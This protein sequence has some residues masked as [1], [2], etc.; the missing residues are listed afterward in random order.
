MNQLGVHALVWVPQWSEAECECALMGAKEAGYD[1]IEIPLLD[2]QQVDAG[3]TR[4]LLAQYGLSAT[5]SLGL[6]FDT[7]V[8]S[9]DPETSRRGEELL[10]R[11]VRV[12]SDLGAHYLGGV[13]YSAMGKYSAPAAPTARAQTAK[14][15]RRVAER[16]RELGVTVGLEPVNRYESNLINTARQALE[17]IEEIGVPNVVVHLDCYHRG[18]RLREAGFGVW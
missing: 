8:S 11:A 9:S 7:D 14:V 18:G 10:L 12:T 2:P 13:V 6:A 3:M 17:L 4:R 5:C 1:F 16:G 15:L